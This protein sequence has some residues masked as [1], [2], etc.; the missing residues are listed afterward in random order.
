[1]SL[2]LGDSMNNSEAIDAGEK[3]SLE[4]WEI[5]DPVSY[6]FEKMLNLFKETGGFG[7]EYLDAYLKASEEVQT[8]CRIFEKLP[9]VRG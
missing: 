1:M 8:V 9:K 4:D 5:F 6:E 7:D 2:V 3:M